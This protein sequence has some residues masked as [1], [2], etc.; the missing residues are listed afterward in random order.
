MKNEP[1]LVVCSFATSDVVRQRQEAIQVLMAQPARESGFSEAELGDLKVAISL[2]VEFHAYLQ[3]SCTHRLCLEY[4]C[5]SIFSGIERYSGLTHAYKVLVEA[6]ESQIQWSDLGSGLV[7]EKFMS[8]FDTFESEEH[9]EQK[10]RL[11]LDLF[12]VQIVFAGISYD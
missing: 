6:T 1:S 3:I 4:A 12:K 9:F 5:E 11:L 10:C 2:T 8:M 7:K